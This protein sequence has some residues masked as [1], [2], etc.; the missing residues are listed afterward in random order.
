MEYLNTLPVWLLL[1]GL[2][3]SFAVRRM[4]WAAV[5]WMPTLLCY[6][7][8]G[9][10]VF[11]GAEGYYVIFR[12]VPVFIAILI[13]FIA[14][15]FAWPKEQGWSAIGLIAGLAMTFGGGFA[16]SWYLRE[17]ITIQIT[18]ESGKP[19]ENVLAEFSSSNAR[20]TKTRGEVRSGA[21]GRIILSSQRG[22]SHGMHLT[23]MSDYSKDPELK[24]QRT[25]VAINQS[26]AYSGR[27]EVHHGWKSINLTQG[28]IEYVPYAK[29]L[30]LT[31]TLFPESEMD[32]PARRKQVRMAFEFLRDHPMK[33][34]PYESVCHNFEALDLLP[35]LIAEWKENMARRGQIS[36]AMAAIA[37]L[38]EGIDREIGHD[39]SRWRWNDRNYRSSDSELRSRIARLRKWA[40]LPYDGTSLDRGQMEEVRRILQS[41]TQGLF[42]FAMEFAEQDRGARHVPS[43]LGNLARPALSE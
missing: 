13:G 29:H 33:D 10:L 24:P 22:S 9:Y 2:A 20:R 12:E 17:T 32:P 31:V 18:D 34:A 16:Y 35:D 21:D 11:E 14:C 23:P 19:I 43:E 38:L 28:Y 5:V 37:E 6:V 40:G 3:V 25:V 39:L 15:C 41:R 30:T 4:K 27:F 7:Y 36:A 8:A 26:K 42:D 1:P